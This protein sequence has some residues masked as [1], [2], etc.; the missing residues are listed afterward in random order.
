MFSAV[1]AETMSEL[2]INKEKNISVTPSDNK[3]PPAKVM[4]ITGKKKMGI[5]CQKKYLIIIEEDLFKQGNHFSKVTKLTVI[6]RSA[7]ICFKTI[8]ITEKRQILISSIWHKPQLS[9]TIYY[10]IY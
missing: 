1:D 3:S 5:T 9:G 7:G 6:Y 8:I 10:S 2:L 4:A